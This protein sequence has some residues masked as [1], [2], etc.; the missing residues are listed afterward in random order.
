MS[1]S[2]TE[3]VLALV[4]YAEDRDLI[5]P[6]ERTYTAN[7]LLDALR[8]EA[9]ETFHPSRRAS[10]PS[11]VPPL[12]EILKVLVDDAVERKLIDGGIASRDLF[13]TRLMSCVTPR[14]GQVQQE[15]W[16]RY[17]VSPKAATDW[18]YQLSKDSDY[19]R[20]YRIARDRKWQ[21]DTPYGLLDITINLSK[22]EK[23]P[24]AIAA[25]LNARQDAYPQC[26][27]CRENEGYAGRLDHP[28]RQTIRLIPLILAG[29]RW[30]LQYSPYVYYQEH[31]IVLKEEH[32]PMRIDRTTFERLLEFCELFP[33]YTIGSNADLP[34]VGGSILT[35]EHY[36][37]GN[38]TFAMAR[39]G[40]RQRVAFEGFE[41]VSAGIVEWP[42][43]VVRLDGTDPERL[44][45]LA[46]Q[47]LATWRTYTDETVGVSA[48][49]DGVPHNTITPIARRCGRHFELDLV[50]RNNRTSAEHP[51]GIF[52]PHAELHHIKRE[53]IGL[54]EVMGLAILP[55]RLLGEMDLLEK[56]IAAG[57]DPDSV[58]ELAAHAQWAHDIIGRHPELAA[59]RVDA[60]SASTLHAIIQEEIGLAFARVLEHCAVFANDDEGTRAFARFLDCVRSGL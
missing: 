16:S 48:E 18:F 29:E 58:P 27:L 10:A 53:N 13:D 11:E 42:M 40:I 49:S 3:M 17:D 31:C 9:D 52:H 60:V 55:A 26:L 47:I 44:V 1:R 38:Y 6:E 19:I 2:V 30:Y 57:V 8:L 33:H 15:F 46:D 59:D 14:P 5:D 39:A 34:I 20:T 4:D 32:V 51:L 25:A 37:G 22:P 50:L 35:H 12:E 21:T 7:L 45:E 56:T 43:S 41:D 28:A 24:K 36:Q 23:D 54:I